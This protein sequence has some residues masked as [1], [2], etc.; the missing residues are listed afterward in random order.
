VIHRVDD[1]LREEA[2]RY[3]LVFT[4]RRCAHVDASGGRDAC[5]LGYPNAPHRDVDLDRAD[6]VTFCKAF[7]V[8]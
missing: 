6:E 3:G 2:R 4:C 8:G 1:V 7:E 5:S